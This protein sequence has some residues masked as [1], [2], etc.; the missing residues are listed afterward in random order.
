MGRFRAGIRALAATGMEPERL[1]ARVD[2]DA[3][4]YNGVPFTTCAYV[5][6][7]PVAGTC[8]LASAGHPPPM[9]VRPDG[10]AEILHAP[11]GIPLGTGLDI[12]FSST[13]HRVDPGSL[14]LLYT[15]GLFESRARHG[16]DGVAA[17]LSR[18]VGSSGS[19]DDICD[20]LFA[21][22][23]GDEHGDDVA[24]LLARL[25]GSGHG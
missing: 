12:V 11:M 5:E 17:V 3:A 19:L 9:V 15:D 25:H 1:L 2:E 7:D 13:R 14:L 23:V 20:T 8:V 21:D 10:A 18:F 4:K 16:G 6:Y 22:L 24:L